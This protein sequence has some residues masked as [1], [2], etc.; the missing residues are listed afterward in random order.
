MK[1]FILFMSIAIMFGFAGTAGAALVEYNNWAGSGDNLLVDTVSGL[2]WAYDGDMS[3]TLTWAEAN[4]WATNLDYANHTNWRLPTTPVTG[5]EA[6]GDADS[7]DTGYDVD[8]ANSDMGTL[9]LNDDFSLWSDMQNEWYWT[10]TQRDTTYHYAFIFEDWGAFSAGYQAGGSNA[11]DF[12]AL[13]VTD[14]TVVPIPG[15]L[16]LLGSGLLGLIGFRRVRK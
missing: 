6:V 3:G 1:K 10:D 7:G 5:D 13:A 11:S 16:W 14:E 12:Y 2:T 4:T 8:A 15:A 9:Y